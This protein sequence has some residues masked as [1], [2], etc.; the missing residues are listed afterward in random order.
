MLNHNIHNH[1]T[2]SDGSYTPEQIVRY[3]YKKGLDVVGISDHYATDKVRSISF[4][5][6]PTY[7]QHLRRLKIENRSKI[8]LISGVEIDS[9]NVRTALDKLDYR[10]L[11]K[12]NFVL[13]EYVQDPLWAGMAFD[14]FIELSER[15]SVPVGLA[16]MDIE[17]CFYEIDPQI[18][19]PELEKHNI[20]IELS[21]SMRYVR[22]GKQ[23]YH[24]AEDFFMELSNSKVPIAVGT[25]THQD[26]NDII[27]IYDATEFIKKMNLTENLNRFFKM[28]EMQNN[29]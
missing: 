1:T 2:Y 26:A 13:F 24:L 23:Y 22:F 16:H 6:L 14:K 29:R 11:N 17:L 4:E 12:L 21:S 27:D 10:Q 15:F 18:V 3:A 7:I 9:S 8:R 19:I 25:D 5:Q 20:F 28:I